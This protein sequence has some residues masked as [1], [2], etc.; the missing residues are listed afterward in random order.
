MDARNRKHC[1]ASRGCRCNLKVC[2]CHRGHEAVAEHLS[3]Q[4]ERR[5]SKHRW[6]ECRA[7]AG[8]SF[9]SLEKVDPKLSVRAKMGRWRG[10]GGGSFV[11]SGWNSGTVAMRCTCVR[12]RASRVSAER[13]GAAAEC[14]APCNALIERDKHAAQFLSTVY[15]SWCILT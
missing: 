3:R 11:G 4:C 6:Q 10:D 2:Q 14:L 8:S 13:D 12:D 1:L 9:A 7:S 5:D 15:T